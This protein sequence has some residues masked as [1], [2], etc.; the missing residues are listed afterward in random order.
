MT[1][2]IVLSF[3]TLGALFAVAH[4]I[5]LQLALYWYYWWFDVVMHFWGGILITLCL[6]ALVVF[7]RLYIRPTF[8][9]V[10]LV[11]LIVTIC[12]EVF[13]WSVG[14][15]QPKA[16]LVDTFEDILLGSSGGLLAHIILRTYTMR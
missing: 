13:E 12:W 4:V 9:S 6:Y 15:W 16:Y 10:L 11:L 5:A 1:N 14:L 7:P 3:V 2:R 8:P